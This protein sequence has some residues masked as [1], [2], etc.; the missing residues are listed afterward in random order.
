[1]EQ[2]Q[3][4]VRTQKIKQMQRTIEKRGGRIDAIYYSADLRNLPDN[5][6]KPAP[7]MA[8]AAKSDFPEISFHKSIM[9]G[10]SISDMQFG[11]H[12]GMKTVLVETN[13]ETLEELKRNGQFSELVDYRFSSLIDFAKSLTFF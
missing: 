11:V 7:K 9:V 4:S 13:A 1:M 6:R 10:D 5:C 2:Y 8:F 3:Q 12:L